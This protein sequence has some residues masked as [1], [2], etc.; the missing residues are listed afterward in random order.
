MDVKG[1]AACFEQRGY[2]PCMYVCVFGCLYERM[3][4]CLGM[5]LWTPLPVLSLRP[6]PRRPYIVLSPGLNPFA[7]EA[8]L[9]QA[10]RKQRHA[11][12]LCV[13]CASS[14]H[15]QSIIFVCL[16]RASSFLLGR[17]RWKQE[18]RH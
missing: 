13:V 2:G 14:I 16:T 3:R 18:L 12:R 8:V 4:L 11:S 7:A 15:G 6:C 1:I 5:C 9:V 10:K 17:A